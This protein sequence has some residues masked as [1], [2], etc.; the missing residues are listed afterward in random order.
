MQSAEHEL[1][2]ERLLAAL[3]VR[4][5]SQQHCTH[6]W[7]HCTHKQGHY[8]RCNPKRQYCIRNLAAELSFCEQLPFISA[9]LPFM[10]AVP[11]FMDAVLPFVAAALTYSA[12]T[13]QRETS[14]RARLEMQLHR[15]P[16]PFFS[17][18]RE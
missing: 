10:N 18:L 15:C 12:A 5:H 3:Q 14:A 11:S 7:L 6:R 13:P 9:V 17:L 16:D 8:I 4:V 2:T 1:R